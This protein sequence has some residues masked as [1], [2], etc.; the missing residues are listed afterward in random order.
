MDHAFSDVCNYDTMIRSL[1]EIRQKNS[2]SMEEYMLQIHEAIA[3]IHCTYPDWISDQGKNLTQDRFHHRLSPSL[4]DAL[5]FAMTE[6]P[7]R[8]KVNMSFDTLYM[9]AK[10]M[11]VHQPS[12]S[13]RGRSGPSDAYR[14][15]YRRYPALMGRV[16]TLEDEE[17]FL[18][19]PEV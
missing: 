10:K 17:L 13:H 12:R 19:D 7:E 15:K 11:E 18:P 5:G 1:Y 2:E 16:A 14:N 9:L 6:L 3:V 4:C 8:E